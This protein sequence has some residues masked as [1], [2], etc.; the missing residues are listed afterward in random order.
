MVGRD[1]KVIALGEENPARCFVDQGD[2]NRWVQQLSISNNYC[3]V[4]FYLVQA[5]CLMLYK[6]KGRYEHT[7]ILQANLDNYST[8]WI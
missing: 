8:A 6:P 5:R 7:K 4:S 3:S 2:R 1:C